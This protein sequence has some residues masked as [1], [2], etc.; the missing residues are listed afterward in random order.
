MPLK[1]RLDEETLNR[2]AG[3]T[4]FCWTASALGYVTAVIGYSST[5]MNPQSLL[6]LGTVLFVTTLG[7]DRLK[8]TRSTSSK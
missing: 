7:L 4:G 8:Q 1:Q 5:L 6:Y 2:V 3:I